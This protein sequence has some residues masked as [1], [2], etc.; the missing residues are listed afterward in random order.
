DVLDVV[1][2]REAGAVRL[3]DVQREGTGPLGHPAHRHAVGHVLAAETGELGAPG[4]RGDVLR[5]GGSEAF[6][7]ALAVHGRRAAH[8]GVPRSTSAAAPVTTSAT[9]S[10]ASSS[11]ASSITS[12]GRKR[13]TLP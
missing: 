4:V 2:A 6:G 5:L 11:N 10:K 12:G 9:T 1:D 8:A 7:D 3:R 13:S